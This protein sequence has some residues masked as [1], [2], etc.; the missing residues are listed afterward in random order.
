MSSFG[1]AIV[2]AR[3]NHLAALPFPKSY[4]A[5]KYSATNTGKEK[6]EVL[7]DLP[8]PGA[9]RRLWT[10]H[11]NDVCVRLFIFVDGSP[12]PLIEGFAHEL[13]K[14]GERLC[15]P[16]LPLAGYY[17]RRSGNF[18]AEIPFRH[19]LRIEAEPAGET[20]DGPYWQIDYALGGGTGDSAPAVRSRNG[21]LEYASPA[22]KVPEAGMP[23]V[24][25]A[26]ILEEFELTQC[27]PHNLRVP[28]PAVIRQLEIVSPALDQLI[29]R[30]AFDSDGTD[31]SRVD[32]PFQVDAPLRYLVGNFANA[33]V[34][35]A[36]NTATIFFPMPLRRSACLQLV[37]SIGQEDFHQKYPVKVRIVC[38]AAP[39]EI[40]NMFYFHARFRSG[41][42]NGSDDFECCS[43]AGRGHF[44]GAHIFDTGH[45]HGGGEN[46]FFDAGAPSAGQ[47]HGICGEDYFHMAY[48]RTGNRTPY[49]GCPTH[50]A[51]YRHHLEMPIPF[52][53][54][55]VF[56]WGAF[57]S[58]S[59]KAVA[60]WYQESPSRPEE[61]RERVWRITGPFAPEVLEG[62]NPSL[63][64]PDHAAAMPGECT[65]PRQSWNKTAQR[66]FV[67]LCHIHRRY[68]RALPPSKGNLQVDICTVAT[69]R[70]WAPEAMT[71]LVR[72]GCDDRIRLYHNGTLR[73][74]D[75]G[76]CGL[77]P[78]QSFA[79]SLELNAGLNVLTVV[80]DNTTNTNWGWNGFS[81]AVIPQEIDMRLLGI[82]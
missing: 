75:A 15:R 52:A 37:A 2:F 35:R 72:L 32:G 47:L 8:G 45:D 25:L 30:I 55:F 33:G 51:R 24:G 28:G 67:D 7:V 20:G 16:D 13:A 59:A 53:E 68:Y 66:G 23:P 70:I 80:V 63:P 64:L 57:A 56:N 58:Q 4:R 41:D 3:Q 12:H 34:E 50:S 14:S 9:L 71:I 48:M 43:T 82:S 17:D 77:D 5:G 76:R 6:R 44:V 40:E 54:S 1:E 42:T 79:I 10:T 74:E 11:K 26:E 29:L 81:F 39:E 21:R 27:E 31:S 19:A 78:F 69:T 22:G 18:Y 65:Q 60:L 62:W 61:A 38:D 49:S 46:I 36:E 73:F